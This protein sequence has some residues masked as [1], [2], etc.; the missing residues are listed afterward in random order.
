MV[1]KN[2]T[3][4][5][6]LVAAFALFQQECNIVLLPPEVFIISVNINLSLN[7]SIDQL[8]LHNIHRSN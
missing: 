4:F 2:V 5:Q 8:S 1:C 6:I 3:C 7:F